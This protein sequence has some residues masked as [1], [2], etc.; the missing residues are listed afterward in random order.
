[1]LKVWILISE[2]LVLFFITVCSY[3][4]IKEKNIYVAP[5]V[6][7]QC[8]WITIFSISSSSSFIKIFSN[9]ATK[10]VIETVVI[11][12][13]SFYHDM[14]GLGDS[15][16]LTT[17]CVILGFENGITIFA[18]AFLMCAIAGIVMIFLKRRCIESKMPL[19][20]FVLTSYIVWLIV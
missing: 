5:V 2:V 11:T 19:A 10:I 7:S 4:D 8:L 3:T 17:V 14:I 20:P 13:L 6:L 12:V 1:M 18:I 16:M 9:V 15:L